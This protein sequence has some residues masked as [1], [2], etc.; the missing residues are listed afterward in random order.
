M[1]YSV[2]TLT[3]TQMN[4]QA[5]NVMELVEKQ[6]YRDGLITDPNLISRN[7]TIVLV[8]KNSVSD[9][10]KKYFLGNVNENSGVFMIFKNAITTPEEPTQ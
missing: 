5:N 8:K 6:L 10:F 2:F 9:W 7:Y 4:E 3:E 1:S